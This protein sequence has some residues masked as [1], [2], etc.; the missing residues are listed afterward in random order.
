M[1]VHLLLLALLASPSSALGSFSF[2][3]MSDTHIP[4][5]TTA[6][7]MLQAEGLGPVEMTPYGVTAPAPSFVIHTGDCTEFGG[8]RGSWE[9]FIGVMDDIG[10]P[11]YCVS[12]NHDN[13]W[14]SCRPRIAA[15]YGAPCYSFDHGGV[16]FV[17]LDSASPQDPRPC[18]GREEILWLQ[19]DLA[20]VDP[21]TPIMLF[22]HHPPSKEAASA[23]DRYR[24]YDV[25]RGHNVVVH[26]VGHGH[27]VRA[28]K[29][30]G[31][32]FAM[33]GSTFGPNA[34]FAIVDVRGGM[35]RIAYRKAGEAT[36][37][38]P[39][40][41]KPL[42]APPAYPKITITS[43]PPSS[44]QSGSVLFEGKVEGDFDSA[45][46]L[47]DDDK[48]FPLTLADDRFRGEVALTPEL[49]G[50]HF[51][52]VVFHGPNDAAAWRS[53]DFVADTSPAVRVRWR[54]LLGGSTK[55]T[56]AVWGDLVLVGADDGGLYA[57]GRRRG[58]VRWSVQT[59]GDV[60]GG[61]LVLGDRAYVGS[62]DG[63][64]YEVSASG[65]VTRTFDAGAPIYSSPV[66]GG[67]A[68][69][70]A[71]TAGTVHA[72]SRE[73]FTEAWRCDA[74][75]YAIEDTLFVAGDA[76]CFGAWDTYVYALD[77]KT[78]AVRWRS[79]A[80]GTLEGGAKQYYSPA[81]C[82]PVVCGNRVY[83][84]DRK[85]YL[86]VM[87]L[88]TGALLS[89]RKEVSGVGLSEDGQSVYLRTT[90]QGLVKLDASGNEVWTADVPLGYIAAAPVE[91]DGVVY[92][93]ST[94][95]TLSAVEAASGKVLWTLPALPGFYAMADPAAQ[96]GV[97]YVAGMDGSVTA[98]GPR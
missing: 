63:K 56:P 52:R 1:L 75:E 86:S 31:Y 70:V 40:I 79:P 81:D 55:S 11:F 35:L 60:L 94:L 39:L 54:V 25:L 66:P 61:P 26:L 13:T 12:G 43:P 59:G 77:A 20:T 24:L 22:Y 98:L 97:V 82:G 36:A 91:R 65:E 64:L 53:G 87:D 7:V 28:W 29:E 50:A 90:K 30:E 83:A 74:P 95:G 93:L 67:E 38:T 85:Y 96:D 89:S 78:G 76:I 58:R 71:T 48:P 27:G 41:E 73:T 47:L 45:E 16:H 72:V 51:Y 69:M 18:I 57:L 9:R 33:G 23:Y 21:G 68:I 15:R 3:H 62:G 6:E 4:Y 92:S 84:A 8:G 49:A 10:L 32:D 19:E 46:V 80:A 44:V 88:A 14:D 34:G 37:A 2:I 17:G 5:S 42:A